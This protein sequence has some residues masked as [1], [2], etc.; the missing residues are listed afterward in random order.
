MAKFSTFLYGSSILY[1]SNLSLVSIYPESGPSIGGQSFVVSGS[2]LN[3]TAYNDDFTDLV[4]DTTKWL[5][6]SAGAGH[7]DTG[8]SHLVLNTGSIPGAV[9][10]IEMKHSVIN[11]Q[12]E[13]KIRI[14]KIVSY[15]ETEVSL[16]DF[17][18]YYNDDNRSYFSISLGPTANTLKLKCFVYA[19]GS[20]V[21]YYET[22]WTTG[23]ATLKLLRW[24]SDIYFYANGSLLFKSERSNIEISKFRVYACN[25]SAFYSVD[26]V[27][28]E[29]I[30]CKTY[31]AFDNQI[32]DDLTVVS[33]VRARGQTPP[34][35]DLKDQSAAYA[36]LVNIA[37]VADG[38]FI[39]PDF[40][41]YYFLDDLIL[42]N[43]VKSD[44]KI[45]MINDDV[46]RTPVTS[47]KG[48]GGGK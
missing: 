15:P 4:L 31:M 5:D 46:V 35:I 14:P 12:Y 34:S 37:I 27:I 47:R 21:D 41:E 30:I 11:S 13:I 8:A 25:N 22:A 42:V 24:Y 26:N 17:S 38:S 39:V 18:L 40:Y 28:V 45:N 20:L 36:G 44:V 32:V 33:N 48:L 29:N 2:G 6:I 3:F 19:N 23:L 10:G 1:G 7:V 43:D 16:L 9:A